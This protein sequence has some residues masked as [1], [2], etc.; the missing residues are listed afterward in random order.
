VQSNTFFPVKAVYVFF[1]FCLAT[2]LSAN[3][4][5][6][7]DLLSQGDTL[8]A[9]N[10]LLSRGIEQK[11]SGNFEKGLLDLG[12]ADH[13]AKAIGKADKRFVINFEIAQAMEALG[14][15]EEAN[16]YQIVAE[17]QLNKITVEPNDALSFYNWSVNFFENT[18][19]SAEKDRVKSLADVILNEL[20]E[21]KRLEE[22]AQK[23]AELETQKKAEEAVLVEEDQANAETELNDFLMY[24]LIGF[25]TVVIFVLAFK[26]S[27]R[28]K[29]VEKASET[30][31]KAQKT[32][33]EAQAQTVQPKK[34]EKPAE[35][36]SIETKPAEKTPKL[37]ESYFN[38]II[39]EGFNLS[40]K[41][42]DLGGVFQFMANKNGNVIFITA[43]NI[44]F[45]TPRSETQ[46]LNAHRVFSELGNEG[47]FNPSEYVRRLSESSGEVGNYKLSVF[48]FNQL[49]KEVYFKSNGFYLTVSRAGQTEWHETEKLDSK[50]PQF[51]AS[52][53]QTGTLQA[54]D[55]VFLCNQNF[56]NLVGKDT[57]NDIFK[58]LENS[59]V[60]LIREAIL[61]AL[62]G[63]ITNQKAKTDIAATLIKL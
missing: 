45:A 54:N 8:G 33:T 59:D 3:A 46:N 21:I 36:K 35:I 31:K 50:S 7:K 26:F 1:L 49:T 60:N 27:K 39:K 57:V 6:A 56:I 40:L 15:V 48:T 23:Q 24:F 61:K 11:N 5:S 51:L 53:P 52:E 42:F 28:K 37:S 19:N 32:S 16:N 18:G 63:A 58:R 55:L 62:N 17:N 41:A 14:K 10:L 44:F 25:F 13:W 12:R 29:K 22:E 9:V 47:E 43:E 38:S 4:T 2:N 30:I 20:A 34:A